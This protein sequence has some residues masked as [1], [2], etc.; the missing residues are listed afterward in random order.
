M[1]KQTE[2]TKWTIAAHLAAD[3]G[4]HGPVQE[5]PLNRVQLHKI[6]VRADCGDIDALLSHVAWQQRK[7]DH[8]RAT[9]AKAIATCDA[10]IEAH[11]MHPY[12]VE[13]R[14]AKELRTVLKESDNA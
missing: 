3:K 10:T 14:V 2:V 9:I 6:A 8:L 5:E 7:I 1:T 4:F 13:K 12:S 11:P